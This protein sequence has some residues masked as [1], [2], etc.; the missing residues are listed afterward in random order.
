MQSKTRRPTLVLLVH[1]AGSV[2]VRSPQMAETLLLAQMDHIL[3]FAYGSYTTKNGEI[4]V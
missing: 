4:C 2:T 1:R 3:L